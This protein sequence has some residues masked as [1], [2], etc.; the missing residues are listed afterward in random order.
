VAYDDQIGSNLLGEV[1]HLFGWLASHQSF[2]RGGRARRR[3]R[4]AGSG[5]NRASGTAGPEQGGKQ[6]QQSAWDDQKQCELKERRE[7]CH[8]RPEIAPLT[9]LNRGDP[10]LQHFPRTLAMRL[11]TSAPA[12]VS[13]A[14]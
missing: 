13:R 4:A 9:P 2:T 11:A 6:D 3:S 12:G 5:A 1:S 10:K 14:A 7:V 8:E